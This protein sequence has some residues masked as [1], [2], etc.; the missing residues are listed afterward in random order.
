MQTVQIKTGHLR[1]ALV[2]A[3]IVAT[4]PQRVPC[5]DGQFTP[6][7]QRELDADQAVVDMAADI[8]AIF[9]DC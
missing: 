3:M 7:D 9:E 4:D 5:Y 1:G 8:F 2:E 6:A